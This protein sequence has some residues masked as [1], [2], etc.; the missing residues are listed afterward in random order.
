[1]K[2]TF[3]KL[4]EPVTIAVL[5]LAVI[6]MLVPL[7]ALV[8]A[9]SPRD[10]LG[11]A[12]LGAAPNLLGIGWVLAIV[13]L[14]LVCGLTEPPTRNVAR[15][16]AAGAGVVIAATGIS[17]VFLV[18]GTILAPT[19]WFGA[20][21]DIVGAV[22]DLGLKALGAVVLWRLWRHAPRP[23]SAAIEPEAAPE[24]EPADVDQTTASVEPVWRA[25]EAVGAQWQRAGDA[26][27]GAEAAKAASTTPEEGEQG[28]WAVPQAGVQGVNWAAIEGRRPATDEPVDQ[29]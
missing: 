21:L 20:A 2:Q 11:L 22:I 14:V 6:R 15:L 9:P 24:L 19:N 29:A 1:M 4:R 17:F 16:A 12:L 7:A 3:E 18:V 23:E 26:A 25:D 13:A 8:I 27:S 10:N 28:R 5:V